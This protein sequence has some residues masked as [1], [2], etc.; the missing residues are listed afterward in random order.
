V[1]VDGDV[2]RNDIEQLL[3]MIE[4]ARRDGLQDSRL[5]QALAELLRDRREQLEALERLQ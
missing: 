1:S 5:L 2:L 4:S 3:K